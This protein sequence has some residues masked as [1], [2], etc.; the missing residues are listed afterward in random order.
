MTTE[1]SDV[2]GAKERW[3]SRRDRERLLVRFKL[4]SAQCDDEQ[5]LP[6]L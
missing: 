3:T 6:P 2:T 5:D 1:V 4:R